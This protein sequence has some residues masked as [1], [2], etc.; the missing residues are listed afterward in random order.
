MAFVGLFFS[1]FALSLGQVSCC[2]MLEFMKVKEEEKADV[3][4]VDVNQLEN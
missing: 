4:L 3:T 2:K 1:A